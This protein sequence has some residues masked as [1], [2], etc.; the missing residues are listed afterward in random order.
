MRGVVCGLMTTL[1]GIGHTLPYLIRNFH[2]A[3]AVAIFVVAI[4]LAAISWIRKRF[5][6]T[7]LLAAT[8]QVV[9]GGV[10]VFLAGILI[11]GARVVWR[12]RGWRF[13]EEALRFSKL[14]DPRTVFCRDL[15]VERVSTPR[16]LRRT[17]RDDSCGRTQ[18]VAPR[19]TLSRGIIDACTSSM[20]TWI[21]PTTSF[22]VATDKA[23]ER[24]AADCGGDGDGGLAGH[25]AWECGADLAR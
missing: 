13:V 16:S 12:V 5:M 6:D 25:S 8:I 15:G 11:G 4:E 21:F 14:S 24:A 18:W 19:G 22:A 9:I 20:P 23:G 1:G 10:L 17:V 2:V 7:P 3:T